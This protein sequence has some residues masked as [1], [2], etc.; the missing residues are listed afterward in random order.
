MLLEGLALEGM[1]D[2]VWFP[3]KQQWEASLPR[4]CDFEA[5]PPTCPQFFFLP[6]REQVRLGCWLAG[7]RVCRHA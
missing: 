1:E 7:W 5:T 3:T 4:G 6:V 2:T